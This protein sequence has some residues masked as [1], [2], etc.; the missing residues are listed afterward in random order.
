MSAEAAEARI[1]SYLE[2]FMA[3]Y[4]NRDPAAMRD[5]F[6]LPLTFINANG[7]NVIDSEAAYLPWAQSVYQGLDDQQFGR[8]DATAISVLELS[9]VAAIVHLDFVRTNASGEQYL[10]GAASYVVA[11]EG[12]DDWRILTVIGRS[13]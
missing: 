13:R 8:T 1:R 12:N 3:S 7:I 2:A 4:A 5:C 9:P 11:T 6:R 10:H